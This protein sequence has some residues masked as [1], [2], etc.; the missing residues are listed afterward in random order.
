LVDCVSWPLCWWTLLK[1]LNSRFSDNKTFSKKIYLL[2]FEGHGEHVFRWIDILRGMGKRFWLPSQFE[3]L[4]KYFKD[5]FNFYYLLYA[6]V[7]I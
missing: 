4:H 7:G 5:D 2:N 3:I 6:H 1:M